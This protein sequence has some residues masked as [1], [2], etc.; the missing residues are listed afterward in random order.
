MKT[1]KFKQFKTKILND[2]EF[3]QAVSFALNHIM[4]LSNKKVIDVGCGTGEMSI[5]FA[6]QGVYVIGFDK[7]IYDLNH[8]RDLASQWNVQD[9]CSFVRGFAEK[10]PI[11][12][13]S[14]DIVF[15]RSTIQYM[16]RQV[17]LREYL[18]I[19]KPTGVLILIEN[20]PHNPFVNT[21]RLYRRLFS[22]TPNQISYLKSIRGYL[23]ISEINNLKNNFYDFFH[24]EYHIF[25]VFTIFLYKYKKH[26][27]IKKIDGLLM[28]LDNSILLRFPFIRNFAWFTAI[29]GKGKIL[30][31]L[32]LGHQDEYQEG[33]E[34]IDSNNIF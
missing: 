10:I 3:G 9:K 23:T 17:V 25:R 27:V 16:K 18:R 33:K 30:N 31:N 8:Y 7:E 12:T 20:L 26:T 29:V 11:N 13:G 28:K 32:Q 4:D 19:L 24:Q 2:P 34:F 5:Y 14:I 1:Y 21:Y 15:S 22:R 6:L